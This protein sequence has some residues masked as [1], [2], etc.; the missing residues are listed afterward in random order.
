VTTA[1]VQEFGL[2]VAAE[3]REFTTNGVLAALVEVAKT[4]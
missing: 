2:P 4:S 3:A 1:A